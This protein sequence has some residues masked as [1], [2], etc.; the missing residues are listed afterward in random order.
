MCNKILNLPPWSSRRI[1]RKIRQNVIS[2]IH[3]VFILII[4]TYIHVLN[5]YNGHMRMHVQFEWYW[6]LSQAICP[7]HVVHALVMGVNAR[8][9]V[10]LVWLSHGFCKIFFLRTQLIADSIL[11][12][13]QN[14]CHLISDYVT[15]TVYKVGPDRSLNYLYMQVL[16]S[17][18]PRSV[19]VRSLN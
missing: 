16:V 5:V 9:Y 15:V 3:V 6:N 10:S 13:K 18:I 1:V 19:Q 12:R 4:K 17:Q 14:F 7:V 2:G 11:L 8:M